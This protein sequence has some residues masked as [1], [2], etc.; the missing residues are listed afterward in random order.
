MIFG[1]ACGKTLQNGGA[2]RGRGVRGAGDPGVA[3]KTFVFI[4][5]DSC[6]FVDKT[7]SHARD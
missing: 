1:K 5:E 7:N 4:R 3:K 6:P 2:R